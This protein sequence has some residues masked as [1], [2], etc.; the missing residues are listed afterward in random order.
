M[1]RLRNR[2]GAMLVLGALLFMGLM[3]MAVLA[4]DFSR[5]VEQSAQIHTAADAGAHA[6]AVELLIHRSQALDSANAVATANLPPGALAPIAEYGRWDDT[7]KVFTVADSVEANAIR[8]TTARNTKYLIGGLFNILPQTMRR[9]SIAWATAPVVA[10][11]CIRPWALPYD[12]LLAKLGISD[13]NHQLTDAD[14][15]NLRNLTPAQRRVR[16]KL[17]DLSGG[18][19]SQPG[20][21][22]AVVIPSF[23]MAATQSYRIPR[24]QT[25]ANEY[26]TNIETETCGPL[27]GVGDSVDTEP[28]NMPGPTISATDVL[29]SQFG[30]GFVGDQC[31]NGNGTVGVPIK[32]VLFSG[33]LQGR[34]PAVIRA[35]GGFVLETMFHNS[36]PSCTPTEDKGEIIGYFD[37]FNTGGSV[38]T[39]G[40]STIVRPILVR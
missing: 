34:S 21:F 15:T 29:C 14:L 27:T 39:G 38:A 3:V 5:T 10:T 17:G 33:Q 32:I 16:L 2:K 31:I 13:P 37:T 26:R 18:G 35:I 9:M 4:I 28:G 40:Q 25:G 7:A 23:W 8:V 20:N 12:S 11:G 36:C 1:L 24:P 30:G 22:N 19:T 6:G